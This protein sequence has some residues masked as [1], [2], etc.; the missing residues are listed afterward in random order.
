MY[1]IVCFEFSKFKK[2]TQSMSILSYE[3]ECTNSSVC[4]DIRIQPKKIRFFDDAF[5]KETAFPNQ[6]LK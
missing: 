2:N 1:E 5:K 3:F 4:R 6:N